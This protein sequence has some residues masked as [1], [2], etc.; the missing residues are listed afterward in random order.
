M[1]ASAQL[2]GIQSQSPA[3]HPPLVGPAFVPDSQDAAVEHHPQ[4]PTLV[5]A[6]Q[7]VVVA[8]G[9]GQLPVPHSQF[10]QLPNDGPALVPVAQVE[11]EP[12]QPQEPT[13]LQDVQSVFAAHAS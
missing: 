12:H 2:C 4:L 11:L 5:H 9:S 6:V 13:S 3:G 8:H 10:E 7:V 1:A